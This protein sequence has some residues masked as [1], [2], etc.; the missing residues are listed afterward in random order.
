LDIGFRARSPH[1]V[2]IRELGIVVEF[3]H[4]E[5]LRLEVSTK[6][7]RDALERELVDG[8]FTRGRLVVRRRRRLRARA[9]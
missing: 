4:G 6:F 8:R 1:S 2:T 5:R 9:R 3:D 7:R